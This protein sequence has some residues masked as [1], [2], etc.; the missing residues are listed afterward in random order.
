MRAMAAAPPSEVASAPLR[1][2]RV[3]VFPGGTE[4]GLEVRAALAHRRDIELFSAGV[5]GPGHA[6]FAFRTHDVVPDVRE[7]GWIEPLNRVISSRGID[8]VIPAHDDAVLA[9]AENADAIDALV[10]GSPVETCRVARSKRAT[11]RALSG[12]VP[13]PRVHDDPGRIDAFPVFAKPD[14]GQGSTGAR[15]V[16]DRAELAL[17]LADGSGLVTEMLPGDEHTIDCFSDRER[18]LLFAGPRRRVATR[19]G[20][21]VHGVPVDD[22]EL[23]DQA[24]RI[25]GRLAFH[26]A[27]FFQTRRDAHGVHRL[28]EVAPRIAGTMALHR[29][30]GVNFPLLSVYEALRLPVGIHVNDVRVEIDRAL[31]NRYRHDLRYSTVYVDLDDT[32]VV[33][34]RVDAG[35]VA[36]LF[37]SLNEGRR[38]VLITRHAGDLDGLLGRLRLVGL[39]DAVVRV[40]GH[41]EKA[42]HIVEPDAILIDDSFRERRIASERLG[43]ATFDS[44]TV[45]M[46]RDDRV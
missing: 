9:L 5:D 40:A 31:V 17:A 42:D 4:I 23:Q 10:V 46:L 41:E 20:I 11:Y 26:G 37:Q 29:A 34:G 16:R 33:R 28:L 32:L 6:R 14:R 36:F 39:F 1:N 44:D 45:E 19:S 3:L 27:W 38:I 2:R 25:A 35:L 21:S 12:V 18:G 8:L 13:V 43:I 7:G 24:R 22:P 30:L 15:I